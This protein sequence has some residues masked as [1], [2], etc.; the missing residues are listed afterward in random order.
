MALESQQTIKLGVEQ[1]AR[2]NKKQHH[3][4]EWRYDFVGPERRRNLIC[5]RRKFVNKFSIENSTSASEFFLVPVWFVNWSAHEL[6]SSLGRKDIE[7]GIWSFFYFH[8]L[9]HSLV[10]RFI[11]IRRSSLNALAQLYEMHSLVM[12][13][14]QIS[15]SS[16]KM[17]HACAH[18]FSAMPM[19]TP[20]FF[21]SFLLFFLPRANSVICRPTRRQSNELIC[22]LIYVCILKQIASSHIANTCCITL[23]PSLCIRQS[24]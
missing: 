22:G 15:R 11:V 18:K 19:L 3:K 7:N 5:S 20:T 1:S 6:S 16:N 23:E 4:I 9:C 10:E 21:L 8:H 12:V 14:S 24:P 13:I 2:F 17:L